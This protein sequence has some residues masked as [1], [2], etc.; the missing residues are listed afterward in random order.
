MRPI[1]PA[2]VEQLLSALKNWSGRR[3]GVQAVALVGSWAAGRAPAEADID[4][5]CVVDDPERCRAD[6]GWMAE[7]DWP[8]A[9]L[10]VGRWT[11]VDYGRARSRHLAFGAGEEIEMSF[12]DA[13]WAAVDPVDHATRRVAADGMRVLHDPNGLLGRL[14]V[15][16]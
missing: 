15:A 8:S 13:G 7:I 11:D 16:L 1:P 3:K 12:V 10:T 9:G 4:G 14:I 5:V 2:Q 6:S